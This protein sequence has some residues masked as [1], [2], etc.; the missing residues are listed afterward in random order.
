[1]KRVLIDKFN[2][3][4]Q[5]ARKRGVDTGLPLRPPMDTGVVVSVGQDFALWITISWVLTEQKIGGGR[6]V[7]NIPS[8]SADSKSARL[9]SLAGRAPNF[10]HIV[11]GCTMVVVVEQILIEALDD[12]ICQYRSFERRSRVDEVLAFIDLRARRLEI[13]RIIECAHQCTEHLWLQILTV[14]KAFVGIT[15]L[16]YFVYKGA[17]LGRADLVGI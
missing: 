4:L 15:V 10:L 1:M 8:L 13:K 17:P 9:K 6:G 3:L 5:C 12:E 11:C 14:V 16:L 7:K 2:G